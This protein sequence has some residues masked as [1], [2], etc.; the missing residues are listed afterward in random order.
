MEAG[1]DRQLASLIDLIESKYVSTTA[2][3]RPLDFAHRAVYFAIDVVGD[4]G[5]GAPF[6]FLANDRDM[7]DYVNTSVGFFPV[8]IVLTL[9]PALADLFHYWP[10]SL[11]LPREGDKVGFGRLMG[12][13]TSFVDRR[14]R[15]VA[16][17]KRGNDLMQ[18]FIDHGM[19]REELTQEI[20]SMM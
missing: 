20:F 4:V 19:T 11:F 1:V 15:D 17:G 9:I 16:D 3:H 2:E 10:L 12:F 6:G 18:S 13:A 7:H 5:F 14:F 8:F